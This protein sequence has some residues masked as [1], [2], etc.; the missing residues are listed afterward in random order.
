MSSES[1]DDNDFEDESSEVEDNIE[2]NEEYDSDSD[3]SD[4]EEAEPSI[5]DVE[6]IAKNKLVYQKT[7]I[8]ENGRRRACDVINLTPGPTRYATARIMSI[9]E[10]FLAFFPPHIER[11]IIDCTNVYG[12][13]H[14]KDWIDVDTNTLHAFYGVLL[15]CGIYK[16]RMEPVDSLFR[17]GE[18]RPILSAIMSYRRFQQILRAMRFDLH[19][20]R[21]ERRQHDKLA[22]IRNVWDKWVELLPKFYNPSSN[23]TIDEDLVGF[24]GRCPFRQYMKNKPAKYGLKFWVASCSSSAYV[25]NMQPYLGKEGNQSEKNQGQR[26]VLDLVKGLRGHNITTDNFFTSYDLGQKLLEKHLTLVGTMRRNKTSIPPALLQKKMP[27][28]SSVFAFTG[29]TTLVTYASR[30]KQGTVLQS[31][32]HHSAKVDDT[33]KKMPEIVS[34]YNATKGNLYLQLVLLSIV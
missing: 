13:K 10:S 30:K 2:E 5:P 19:S 22:P 14:I 32:M 1:D 16:G 20:T 24:R 29:D 21:A 3:D 12:K 33:I 23:V 34:Y 27:L 4:D 9:R 25:W 28:H 15:L 7:A 18:G 26:V 31:T 8:T 17:S 11:I 6:F